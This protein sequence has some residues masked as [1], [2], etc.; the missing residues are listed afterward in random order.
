MQRQHNL[1]QQLER[2]V[3]IRALATEEQVDN[4]LREPTLRL[5]PMEPI[6]PTIITSPNNCTK[7]C[8]KSS[9]PAPSAIPN[10]ASSAGIPVK[11]VSIAIKGPRIKMDKL[12]PIPMLSKAVGWLVIVGSL[13]K[14]GMIIS[15]ILMGSSAMR[16]RPVWGHCY[17]GC[18]GGGNS[19]QTSL[20]FMQ[21]FY[22]AFVVYRT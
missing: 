2:I 17:L 14:G 7:P 21:Y 18:G 13:R 19:I 20:I 10:A 3:S 11:F 6:Q 12:S 5:H 1:Q 22:R 4:L 8:T 9:T 15:V 16:M